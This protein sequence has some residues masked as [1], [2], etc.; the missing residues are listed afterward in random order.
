MTETDLPYIIDVDAYCAQRLLVTC[1]RD[2]ALWHYEVFGK[3][4]QNLTRL[5]W[6]IVE[7]A[8]G[9]PLGYVAHG[10]KLDGEGR[11]HMP[12]FE[13]KP[14][15]S[16]LAVAPGL[17]RYLKAT[18]EAY[19]ARDGKI[20]LRRLCLARPRPSFPD[21]GAQPAAQN[22]PPLRV[23]SAGTRSAGFPA[24]HRAR[25]A[26]SAGALHR[27]GYTGELKL[28]LYRQGVRLTID[29]GRMADATTW[30]PSHDDPGS[31]AFPGL[32]FLQL[33]FGY[34]TLDERQARSPIAG[35]RTTMPAR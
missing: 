2:A 13:L 7:T 35:W 25:P 20:V 27:P 5:E 33:L 21:G 18:G 10:F 1:I 9:E 15:T 29:A 30:R 17:L 14:G 34:R 28:S 31:A 8:D 22:R 24:P 6:R 32:T 12:V 3:S 4:E 26:G 19:A 11:L 16:W 23:V